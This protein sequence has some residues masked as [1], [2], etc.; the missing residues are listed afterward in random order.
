MACYS[1]CCRAAIER[2]RVYALNARSFSNGVYG[3]S[4]PGA[5]RRLDPEKA[6]VTTTSLTSRNA[7]SRVVGY[8]KLQVRSA[9]TYNDLTS[10]AGVIPP[11][12]I[13]RRSQPD[14]E[15][16]NY[17]V[18]YESSRDDERAADHPCCE[19]SASALTAKPQNSQSDAV[20]KGTGAGTDDA[21]TWDEKNSRELRGRHQSSASSENVLRRSASL[22]PS[23]DKDRR[24]QITLSDANDDGDDGRVFVRQRPAS[25]SFDRTSKASVIDV[26]PSQ[27]HRR[28]MS[29]VGQPH[30][31]GDLQTRAA[32][33]EGGD[34]GR[35][36]A[37]I[38]RTCGLADDRPGLPPRGRPASGNSDGRRRRLSG[39]D[40]VAVWATPVTRQRSTHRSKDESRS[41]RRSDGQ[42]NDDKP[43]WD[44]NS[45]RHRDDSGHRQRYHRHHHHH[46][47]RRHGNSDD[48]DDER[49]DDRG[50]R[51]HSR[52]RHYHRRS[53]SINERQRTSSDGEHRV[54]ESTSHLALDD[55]SYRL[56]SSEC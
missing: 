34:P 47:R 3:L 37:E 53:R 10:V 23:S 25:F 40:D 19:S 16:Q 52:Q 12:A 8:R 20:V 48:D 6:F 35:S 26:G 46:H 28:R 38:Q 44:K 49:K 50:T 4:K 17:G 24:R 41:R 1:C 9:Q 5:Q 2:S 33:V 42:I 36:T 13:R 30:P 56:S 45:G 14:P 22:S 39:P 27:R 43:R 32:S 31:P 51:H 11:V 29:A 7:E 18:P 15:P 21:M 55:D 54:A